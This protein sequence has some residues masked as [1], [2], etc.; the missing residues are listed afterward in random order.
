LHF[1]D[2][3]QDAVPIAH[4]PQARQETVGRD[5]VT[6]LSMHRLYEDRGDVL[7][8]QCLRQDRLFEVGDNCLAR[9]LGALLLEK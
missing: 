2:D 6:A 9:L 8:R 5:D 1:V 3:E 4:L 7:R